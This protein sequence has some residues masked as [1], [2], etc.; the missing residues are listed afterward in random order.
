MG[1]ARVN[2]SVFL[3]LAIALLLLLLPSSA[4]G[5]VRVALKKL[6]LDGRRGASSRLGEATPLKFR[7]FG[8]RGSVKD[9]SDQEIVGLSNYMNAQ[10]YGE[11]SIGTPPQKFAAI[12]DTGSSNLWVPS[13]KCFTSIVLR[14]TV[15]GAS[16]RLSLAWQWLVVVN[17]VFMNHRSSTPDL[18]E[19]PLH[20]VRWDPFHG[21]DHLFFDTPG[22]SAAIQYGSGAVAGFLS[23]DHVSV[24]DILVKD[25]IFIETTNEPGETFVAAHF[26]G[27]LGLGFQEIAVENVVPLCARASCHPESASFSRDSAP[28]YVRR[29]VLNRSV[30]CFR[31]SV[32]LFGAA[33][34][35]L[36]IALSPPIAC[37]RA[38]QC[39]QLLDSAGGVLPAPLPAFD[40][41]MMKHQELL[42]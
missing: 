1:N 8:I 22:K 38:S 10:Y 20:F 30:R 41:Q 5:L 28:F 7:G 36:A 11:I 2:P 24:G 15:V 3:L 35:P 25:Q 14:W 23:Q 17:T 39:R 37:I 33:S 42:E 16:I 6:P 40:K 26:D 32:R 18:T 12:F 27:I 13:A 29:S 4:E 9:G 21:Q 31:S 19:D 34:R